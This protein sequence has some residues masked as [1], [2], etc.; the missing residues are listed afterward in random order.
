MRV[1]LSWEIRGET[2]AG[3]LWAGVIAAIKE[4][5]ALGFESAWVAETHD[6]AAACTQ[7]AVFLTYAARLTRSIHLRALGRTVKGEIPVRLVEEVALLDLFSHGR[8]S[9]SPRQR[10]PCG[11]RIS[12]SAVSRSAQILASTP[13]D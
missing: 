13:T 11:F 9:R 2:P 4:A 3:P 1:G 10:R 12:R 7:P 6:C 5:D 8:G